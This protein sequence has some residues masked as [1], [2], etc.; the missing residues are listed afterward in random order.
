MRTTNPQVVY[1][2]AYYP[3]AGLFLRQMRDAGVDALFIGGNAA[4]ND[5][6]IQIA[7][8]EVAKGSL[9][10]QEPLPTDLDYPEAIAFVNEYVRRH[11]A[12]PSTPWPVYAAD[13]LNVIAAA[14]EATRSTD[15]TVLAEYIRNE[16]KINGITG[17]IS[18]EPS[19][20]R[21]GA[22]YKAYVVDENGRIVDAG[23]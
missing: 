6:F 2:T 12:P 11:G 15:S 8:L 9:V 23:Y 13:A 1:F 21:A 18:F 7:G 14:I 19:G 17:P 3:E 10:T 22:I 20:D 4:I 16:L 5:E